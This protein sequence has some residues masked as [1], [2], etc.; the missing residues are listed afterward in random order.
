MSFVISAPVPAL[1]SFIV[2]PNPEFAD[3]EGKPVSVNFKRTMNGA[4]R[5]FVKSN[6][7]RI[8]SWQF[9][10]T[11]A[12]GIELQR[13]FTSYFR[14]KLQIEDHKGTIWQGYLTNDPFE[15][16]AETKARGWPGSEQVAIRVEFQGEAVSSTAPGSCD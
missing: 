16:A 14:A 15:F 11:R 8:L 3:T 10:L 13:F 6:S 5:T 9:R 7:R 2:L 12:K 1:Q 4:K